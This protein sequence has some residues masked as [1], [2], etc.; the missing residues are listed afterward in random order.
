MGQ[1]W[2]PIQA[3]SGSLLHADSQTS[4]FYEDET[5]TLRESKLQIEW[6]KRRLVRSGNGLAVTVQDISER[7]RAEEMLHLQTVELQEEVAERQM[8]QE[9]LQEKA[10]QLEE[11]IEKRRHAQEEL[12]KLN[13]ELEQRVKQ[14]TIEVTEK[15][16]ELEKFN[17]IFVGRELRMV[18][19]KERIKELEMKSEVKG[20]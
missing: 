13:D 1:F 11:E 17:K 15:N 6:T 9:S 20:D 16:A 19:L 14:R 5:R 8:A 10:I 3:K 12:E 2:T 4:G 7:K 18:A